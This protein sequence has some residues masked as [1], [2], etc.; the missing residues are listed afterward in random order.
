ME[1]SLDRIRAQDGVGAKSPAGARA[2]MNPYLA[3]FGLGLVLL[4]TFVLMGRGL[5]AT[6]AFST[7]VAS[8]VAAVSPAQAAA[9]PAFADYLGEGNPFKSWTVFLIVGT[10]FGALVSG[11]LAGRIRA[12]TEH[13]PA[14]TDGRRYGFALLG[15]AIA[16]VGAKIALGC[17]SGQA[18]TGGALLNVGSW[19]FMLAVFAGGYGMAWFVRKLWK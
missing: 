1:A 15:G 19:V 17:T 9:N 7:V 18:L 10:F 5:G 2:F 11:A 8:G 6:G 16:G 12:S 13:G 14:I 4:A 3:G